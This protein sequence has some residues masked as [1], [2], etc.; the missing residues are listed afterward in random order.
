MIQAEKQEYMKVKDFFIENQI[1]RHDEFAQFMQDT[2]NSTANDINKLLAYHHKMGNII[3]IRRH[4][5]ISTVN[6]L[7]KKSH[8]DPYLIAAK[9]ASDAIIA[10]H[11]ALEFYGTAYTTFSQLIYVSR[12]YK[13]QFTYQ[14]LVFRGVRPPA[15]LM[16]NHLY[17]FAVDEINREGIAIKITS[18]ERTIVDIFDKP[19][20]AGGWEEV[21][22]SLE[23]VPLFNAEKLVE[24][25]LLLNKSATISKIG[26]FLESLPEN[27]RIEE[28]L[29]SKLEQ[30][31]Q[32][33][34]YYI[35]RG[36]KSKLFPRWNILVPLEVVNKTWEEPHED[37]I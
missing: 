33:Y 13:A 16:H 18:I 31:V 29:L 34:S 21:W 6:V 22:R 7:G 30:K 10:Y 20:L 15:G 4:L 24:Y 3:N 2:R 27:L 26:Y 36:K 28:R 25:A 37:Y 17:D 1:F 11:S 32:K 12:F 35:D 19:Q 9:A 23:I 5:Y 14:N 8:V